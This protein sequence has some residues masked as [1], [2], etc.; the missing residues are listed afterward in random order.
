MIYISA[1][2]VIAALLVSYAVVRATGE[3]LLRRHQVVVHTKDGQSIRGA[4]AATYRDSI[5]LEGLE[6]LMTPDGRPPEAHSLPGQAL[7]PRANV[8]WFQRLAPHEG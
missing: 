6:Y 7:I 4:L 5:L 3:R 2:I 8:A 1:A